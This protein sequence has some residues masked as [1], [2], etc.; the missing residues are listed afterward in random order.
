MRALQKPCYQGDH[1]PFSF[2]DGGRGFGFHRSLLPVGDE[3]DEA[4]MDVKAGKSEL[5]STKN[6]MPSS[7]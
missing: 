1:L 2:I 3:Q 5:Q 4:W 7:K 6:F